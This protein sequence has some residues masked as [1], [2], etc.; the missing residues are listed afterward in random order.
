MELQQ[1]LWGKVGPD[2]PFQI[3]AKISQIFH[4]SISAICKEENASSPH[5]N[6]NSEEVIYEF[7][8]L[9]REVNLIRR[10]G[11]HTKKF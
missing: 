10:G 4:Q 1:Q 5:S 2:L 7:S 9:K 3:R 8:R 11:I 6:F